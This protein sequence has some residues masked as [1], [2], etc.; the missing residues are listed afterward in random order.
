MTILASSV[1]TVLCLGDSNT[2]DSTMWGS[3]PA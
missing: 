3:G 2:R 1:R